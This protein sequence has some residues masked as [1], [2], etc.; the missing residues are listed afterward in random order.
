MLLDLLRLSCAVGE[1]SSGKLSGS[2]DVI[3]P[4]RP[5]PIGDPLEPSLYLY[6]FPIYSMA[7]VT[8]R[9]TVDMTLNDL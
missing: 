3:S 8:Q 4:Y 5:F 1:A 9:V 2:R 7:N 6:R